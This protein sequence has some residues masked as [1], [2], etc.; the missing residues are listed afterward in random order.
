MDLLRD[1]DSSVRI[2][3]EEDSAMVSLVGD[4]I[5]ADSSI[6][7]R[8]ML[9]ILKDSGMRMASQTFSPRSISFA[10]PEAKLAVTVE[11]LHR[12]FF[13]SPDPEIFAAADVERRLPE[14]AADGHSV[15]PVPVPAYSLKAL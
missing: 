7:K 12:E 6:T 1:L 8:A 10:V 4:G 3:V 2:A 11:N 5:T 15:G 14:A 13:R 9:A